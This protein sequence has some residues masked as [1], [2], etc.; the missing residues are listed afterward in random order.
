ME[1]GPTGTVF[2]GYVVAPQWRTIS[3]LSREEIQIQRTIGEAGWKDFINVNKV[4]LI[5][6]L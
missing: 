1:A 4:A 2:V 6:R 5:D 3:A